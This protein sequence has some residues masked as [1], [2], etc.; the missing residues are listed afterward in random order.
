MR[1]RLLLGFISIATLAAAACDDETIAVP[2]GGPTP[3]APDDTRPTTISSVRPAPLSG[4]TLTV[5][6]GGQRA[7]LSDPDRDRVVI[8]SL[9]TYNVENVVE[10]AAGSEPGRSVED[11][12]GL[13]H[14]ALRSAGAVVTIAPE[15][16]ELLLATP[17]CAAPRGLAF[18]K[19]TGRL[20]VAC[21]GGELVSLDGAGNVVRTLDLGI[22]LRDIVVSGAN[23]L[24]S[25]MRSAEVLNVAADGTV[26]S[27]SAQSPNF[28]TD[29]MIEHSPSVAWR[30]IADPATPGQAL[31]I[32]QMS[33]TTAID[34]S[35]TDGSDEEDVDG[36]S[37]AGGAGPGG[38]GGNDGYGSMFCQEDLVQTAVSTVDQAGFGARYQSDGIVNMR[39][40][41]DLAASPDG[42]RLAV[43]DAK[44][45][46][47]L[48]L[49]RTGMV[50]N[51]SCDTFLAGSFAGGFAD[52]TVAIAYAPSSNNTAPRLLLQTREPARLV[53]FQDGATLADISLGGGARSDT[54]YTL[55]HDIGGVTASGLA[56][57]SCHPEGHD[58]GH[59]WNFVGLGP[60]R[61][62]SLSGT[63]AGTAPFHWNG[64]LPT[65]K[66][67]MTEV[68]SNRMGGLT[69]STE[70]VDALTS[71]LEHLAPVRR[72]GLVD[73]ASVARGQALFESSEVGCA[74]CHSGPMLT[75]NQTVNV[76][77]GE[78]FQVPSL[79]G[80]GTRL[81]IMHDGCAA[82]LDERF[83]PAC[84]GDERHGRTA[85]LS[86]QQRADLVAYMN[87]L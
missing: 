28:N 67:L 76:G 55:F 12:A 18:E 82:T 62:Q 78:A 3:R 2:G 54:G 72:G 79:I 40:A 45:G 8:V 32:H 14:V 13:V 41:V 47:V 31:M 38:P 83:D 33:R 52:E 75:N 10:L 81:P 30:L 80:V 61:T 58:D 44:F 16:G 9:E 68:F 7:I 34:L 86:A 60:R 1:S 29:F 25:R 85:A 73:A 51:N 21:A 71:W 87:T 69:E 22:D 53:V 74:T 56:C 42:Q 15:T 35:S 64:E 57:A 5:I 6:N 27:T 49:D 20:H 77:T 39:L 17:V 36:T 59:V 37:G 84:G 65:L 11:D 48:E 66:A 4:G 23:L 19:A 26:V 70:R 63:L 50:A 43:L 46:G 24:V